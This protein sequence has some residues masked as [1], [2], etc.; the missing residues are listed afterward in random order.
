MDARS[1]VSRLVIAQGSCVPVAV[2]HDH[3]DYIP[4]QLRPERIVGVAATVPT[5]ERD[6]CLSRRCRRRFAWR[7]E[8]RLIVK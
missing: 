6:N 4:R 5:R 8:S 7:D 2:A 1:L 3:A